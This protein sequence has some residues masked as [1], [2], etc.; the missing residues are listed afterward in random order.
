MPFL[1]TPMLRQYNARTWQLVSTLDYEGE[2]QTFTIPRG[3][4]TDFASV[5]RALMFL[6]PPYGA[7]TRAAILH[8][9]LITDELSKDAPSVTSREV[10][11]LF[12]RVM[13]EEGVNF[14]LRWIMWSAV[15]AAAPFSPDRRK[16]LGLWRDLP[17]LLL[18]VIPGVFLLLPLIV[19]SLYIGFA[20][21]LG[22][23]Q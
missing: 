17:A 23:A 20:R 7:Y 5:P 13:R 3:Y 10:D 19:N 18:A 16:G 21:L 22:G 2:S 4:I 11:G 1:G 9:W 6:V 12:R 14:T 8:D 15:R